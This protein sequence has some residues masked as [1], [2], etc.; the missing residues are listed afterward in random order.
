LKF[1][2][3]SETRAPVNTDSDRKH[4]RLGVPDRDRDHRHVGDSSNRERSAR[5][6]VHDAGTRDLSW[7][8]SHDTSR[9]LSRDRSRD[10]LPR[11]ASHDTSS[12]VL[13][14]R[15]R[16]R[17]PPSVRVGS[18]VALSR[19]A[20]R[21]HCH[22][23][24]SE[25]G[26]NYDSYKNSRYDRHLNSDKIRSC[27]RTHDHETHTYRSSNDDRNISGKHSGKIPD[28]YRSTTSGTSSQGSSPLMKGTSS[29]GSSPMM[30]S[31]RST[32]SIPRIIA[33]SSRKL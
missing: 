22:R 10:I 31:S 29:Q 8:P 1:A 14:A 13:V 6:H 19:D 11:I 24:D 30:K 7:D 26:H 12:R 27:D 4:M 20:S 16:S 17:E 5:N 28:K 21:E 15:D 25:R 32:S 3:D 18:R 9:D 23:G 2:I 33:P